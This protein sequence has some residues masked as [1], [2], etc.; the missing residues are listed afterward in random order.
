MRRS[1]LPDRR[2]RL[3]AGEYGKTFALVAFLAAL[4]AGLVLGASW[5]VSSAGTIGRDKDI[6]AHG[7]PASDG[8]IHGKRTSKLGLAWLLADYDAE[9][10][11]ADAEGARYEGDVSFWTVLGGPD[12]D[13]AE[14]RYDPDHHDRF[15]VNWAVDAS[16][17]RWRAVLLMT[18]ILGLSGAGI[19]LGAWLIVKGQRADAQVAAR[20]DEIAL[21]VLSSAPVLDNKGKPTGK[22]TYHLELDDGTTTRELTRVLRGPPLACTP[23]SAL[24]VGLWLPGDAKR[25]LLVEHDLSPLAV[26][27]AERAAS[28]ERA[29]KA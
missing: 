19:L 8:S 1:I 10:S 14:L 27:D 24:V 15:A 25:V 22:R 4:G 6:W 13:H 29:S 20:G 7:I 23:D 5:F 9:V 11:Y 18:A 17:A 26:T 3:R 21:R 28:W 2:F 12:T 16:G